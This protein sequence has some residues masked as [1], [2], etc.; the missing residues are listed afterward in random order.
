MN[1]TTN[2]FT[3]KQPY[4]DE[5]FFYFTPSEE[6]G[7]VVSPFSLE[8][9]GLNKN[10]SIRLE[11]GSLQD[12]K[13][14][15]IN[16]AIIHRTALEE[17]PKINALIVLPPNQG[18]IQAEGLAKKFFITNWDKDS[19]LLEYLKVPLL[20]GTEGVVLKPFVWTEEVI[21]SKKGALLLAGRKGGHKYVIS[22]IELFP[23]RG[24]SSPARSILLLNILKW[25]SQGSLRGGYEDISFLLERE[26]Q[27]VPVVTLS[28]TVSAVEKAYPSSGIYRVK[29]SKERIV[30][31][32]YFKRAESDYFNNRLHLNS[33]TNLAE[34]KESKDKKREEVFS[35][36]TIFFLKA[37]LFLLLLDLVIFVFY[38]YFW[39]LS[40]KKRGLNNVSAFG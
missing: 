18:V 3:D 29:G 40:A 37:G 27:I 23:Y 4:D 34:E 9:L 24:K 17:F 19:V 25:L 32:N 13:K 14:G 7:V 33:L 30:A 21:S 22:G 16:F 11:K 6:K 8:E 26:E 1:T 20:E 10:L 36:D 39:K 2:Y 12:L 15:G 38:P 28:D 35:R 5:S 31:V